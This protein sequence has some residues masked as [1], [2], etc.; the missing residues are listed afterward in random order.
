MPRTLNGF[1]RAVKREAKQQGRGEE[2]FKALD[3]RYRSLGA[4]LAEGL[5]A[6]GIS[7]RELARRSGVQQSEVSRILGGKSAPRVPTVERLASALG[8]VLR[9]TPSSGSRRRRLC[10]R[11]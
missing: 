2:V 8:L 11:V 4:Q 6:A 9:L 7:Q 3:E 5:R 1:L 10:A